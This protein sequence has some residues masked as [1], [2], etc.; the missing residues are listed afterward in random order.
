MAIPRPPISYYPIPAGNK[1]TGKKQAQKAIV[2]HVAQCTTLQQLINWFQNPN[3]QPNQPG[4]GIASSNFGLG[5]DGAIACFVDPFA[6]ND[7]PFANGNVAS[8]AV[9]FAALYRAQNQVNPNYWTTSV[10][11]VGFSNYPAQPFVPT[12]AQIHSGAW[13]TAWIAEQQQYVPTEDTMFGHGEIDS[14]TRPACNGWTRTTWVAFEAAVA[15]FRVTPPPDPSR[16]QLLALLPQLELA[17]K[18]EA[19]GLVQMRSLITALPGI[20][21]RQPQFETEGRKGEE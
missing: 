2:L 10:E 5:P 6:T 9:G 8:P 7:C 14:I 19:A 15:T 13:L 21:A 4:Q 11:W 20:A 1:W 3:Q 18:Q 16:Q 17:N 12:D